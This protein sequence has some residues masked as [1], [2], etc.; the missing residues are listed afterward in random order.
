[1]IRFANFHSHVRKIP[2]SVPASIRD[3]DISRLEHAWFGPRFCS[4]RRNGVS[5]FV[6][7][8]SGLECLLHLQYAPNASI[9]VIEPDPALYASLSGL[10][11]QDQRVTLHND[12]DGFLQNKQDIEVLDFV[13][14]DDAHYFTV[15][16]LIKHF[17]IRALATEISFSDSIYNVS[18]QLR[19][20]IPFLYLA[21]AS[22]RGRGFDKPRPKIAVSV[23]VPAYG[24]AA[25]LPQCLDSLVNQTLDE[26]EI[27]VV[28]DGSPDKCGEIADGY[29]ARYPG[30]VV[31]VH[32]ANGGC[33][34]ARNAGMD[35]AK[36]QFIGFVDGDDWVTH[37][38]YA[39][40][41]KM[42][43]EDAADVAQGGYKF[44]Y[45]G[46]VTKDSDDIYAGNLGIFKRSGVV[47][48]PQLLLTGQPTIWRRI[49]DRELLIENGI[50]FPEHIKRFDDLPFQFEALS[51][52]RRISTTAQPYY[53]YRQGRVGQDILAKD[54]KLFVHFE[55]FD[56]LKTRIIS[57][58]RADVISQLLR[59]E[60]NTHA[61]ALGRID[62]HLVSDYTARAIRS[63]H[64]G[65]EV[66]STKHKYVILASV[67]PDAAE[68]L[69]NALRLKKSSQSAA[70]LK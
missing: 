4:Q 66:L 52:A 54:E 64:D 46:G 33:A 35:V 49:Y 59:V 6:G 62:K 47:E 17:Q 26:L 14:V 24:V 63:L 12:L 42:T 22:G 29:A 13:R 67:G 8:R 2:L 27:I 20:H 56:Y 11:G 70:F 19:P 5:L 40:L 31:V 39:D 32:K 69:Q 15:W 43:I 60:L 65:Y 3:E 41:Y 50:R 7:G 9:H 25:Q 57:R 44:A 34:S 53:F 68:L 21:H 45:E 1:M 48:Q 18:E 36:G 30:R 58:M 55:I 38:M 23:I 61:W 10:L 16:K 51:I 37:D 28:D